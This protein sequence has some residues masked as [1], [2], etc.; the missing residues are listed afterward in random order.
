MADSFLKYIKTNPDEITNKL[1][2]TQIVENLIYKDLRGAQKTNGFLDAYDSEICFQGKLYSGNIYIFSYNSKSMVKYSYRGKNFTF[3]DNLPIILMTGQSA[4]CIRGLNLNFCTKPLKALILNMMWN[5]DTE[6][7]ESDIYSFIKNKNIP[8]SPK[9]Q[10]FFQSDI[11]NKIIKELNRY[12]QANY[13]MLFRN[14]AVSNIQKIRLVEPWQWKF[15]PF[16]SFEASLKGQTL[17]A[18]QE[19]NGFLKVRI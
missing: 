4:T 13:Q 17:K 5:I 18:I 3:E 7:Y 2:N 10:T 1:A 16:L 9:I 8:L 19:V 6:Y 15:L 14:Y 12:E 11:E